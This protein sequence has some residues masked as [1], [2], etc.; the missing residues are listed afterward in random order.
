MVVA[1]KTSTASRLALACDVA[2]ES[3]TPTC[4]FTLRLRMGRSL[5]IASTFMPLAYQVFNIVVWAFG[6]DR[7]VFLKSANEQLSCL[8]RDK[9]RFAIKQVL[10]VNGAGSHGMRRLHLIGFNSSAGMATALASGESSSERCSKIV[11]ILSAL[12][13]FDHAGKVELAKIRKRGTNV[14]T[15]WCG[16]LRES[17]RHSFQ[18]SCLRQKNSLTRALAPG[19][20]KD[21]HV[22]VAK[23]PPNGKKMCTLV[24][25]PTSAVH[26]SGSDFKHDN[27][28]VP[29]LNVFSTAL[30]ISQ[31][32]QSFPT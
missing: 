4:P 18:F 5:R 16:R 26:C 14:S 1:V 6:N 28:R 7:R 2:V 11:R 29:P 8:H 15:P 23:S 13:Y 10:R 17:C 20:S 9:P 12:V 32:S 25:R 27:L 19:S 24:S 31:H 30:S 3:N 22:V 21:C